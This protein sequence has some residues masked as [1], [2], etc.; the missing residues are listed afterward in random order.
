MQTGND[1]DLSPV[2][3]QAAAFAARHKNRLVPF[4]RQLQASGT[5][6]VQSDHIARLIVTSCQRGGLIGV[7]LADRTGISLAQVAAVQQ[8]PLVRMRGDQGLQ[9]F[10]EAF[11]AM[12]AVGDLLVDDDDIQVRQI[13]GQAGRQLRGDGSG[14][15]VEIAEIDAAG[16]DA[17]LHWLDVGVGQPIA[18]LLQ[19]TVGADVQFAQQFPHLMTKRVA[20]SHAVHGHRRHAHGFQVV[21]HVPGPA[22]AEALAADRPGGQAGLHGNLGALRIHLP[23]DI[24]AE[25][26]DDGDARA[27]DTLQNQLQVDRL[28]DL[29]S[30]FLHWSG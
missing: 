27:N 28:H 22:Q 3:H 2:H 9:L 14:E 30:E 21:R 19:Q 15:P 7:D 23:V 4:L 20:A 5:D 25:I 10:L 13:G 16:L 24:Q 6:H 18:V 17:L 1:F 8:K 26:A 11:R 12:N 29:F